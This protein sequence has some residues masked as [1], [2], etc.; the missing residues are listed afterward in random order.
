MN[1][2]AF[3]Q[4]QDTNRYVTICVTPIS[5][6]IFYGGIHEFSDPVYIYPCGRIFKKTALGIVAER[7]DV[8]H[9]IPNSRKGWEKMFVSPKC[10]YIP[11]TNVPYRFLAWYMENNF[12]IKLPSLSIWEYDALFHKG[13]FH[14]IKSANYMNM[15][16][17]K[18]HVLYMAAH[19]FNDRMYI[20]IDYDRKTDYD[21]TDKNQQFFNKNA[22]Y[23]GLFI[24]VLVPV[25]EE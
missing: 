13:S 22:L 12:K 23:D 21:Y 6:V 4:V 11:E 1:A 25:I 17:K 3:G 9:S 14:R 5:D 16:C 19:T 10:Y 20:V 7:E 15:S 24:K 8:L 2:V 18:Y